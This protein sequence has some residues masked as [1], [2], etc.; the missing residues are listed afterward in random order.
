MANI[1]E[2]I[3]EVRLIL[4]SSGE[5]DI[6]RC[7]NE[8]IEDRSEWTSKDK[9]TKTDTNDNMTGKTGRRKLRWS[10]VVRKYMKQ[11]GVQREQAHFRRRR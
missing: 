1:S 4:R 9:K 7:G 3:R 2:K 11:K 10:H 6:G 8:N 5:K